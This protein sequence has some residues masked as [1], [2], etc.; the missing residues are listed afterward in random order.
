MTLPYGRQAIDEHDVEAVAVALRAR[1]LTQGPGVEA[2]EVALAEAV[3]A[4]YA[5]A[6][7]SGTA[8]LHAAY[9]V[10]EIGPGSEVLTSPITF[11]A[12]A[13]ASLYLGGG[14]RFADVD[15]DSALLDPNRLEDGKLD[16]VRA[17][18]PVH[19]GGEV[20]DLPAISAVAEARGWLVIEDASHAIGARYRGPDGTWHRV[21]SCAHSE[22]CCFS[23]H[24]VKQLT[25]GEGGAVTTNDPE[26][27]R[28]LRRF[29]SHGITREPIELEQS[30]GPWYYE[31]Q[32]LGYNYRITDFQCALG[33]SQLRRLPDFLARRRT[34]AACYDARFEA[35][36]EVTPL[37]RPR[38]SDGAHHLYVVRV[39][40]ERRLE[41]YETLQRQGI[42]PNV[43]YIPVYRQPFYQRHGFA[44]SRFAGAE[45]YYAGALTL[46]LFPAMTEADVARV[47]DTLTSLFAV[48]AG[49]R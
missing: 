37:S 38:W 3:G 14:V 43:H 33:L 17:V 15:P 24:P 36:G 1:F 21:G 7:S 11:V 47:A 2:F 26:L 46:P 16:H 32:M 28:R 29:R 10:V 41:A 4:R 44:G 12:T 20:A 35:V 40:A 25:T 27:Y 22:M 19:F 18:V 30:D 48:K 34:V 8:A 45:A 31:Q 42:Q 49:S 9:A 6:F 13:N 39:P 5:V 23:F